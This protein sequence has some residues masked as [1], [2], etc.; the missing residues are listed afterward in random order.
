MKNLRHIQHSI[1]AIRNLEEVSFDTMSEESEKV[2]FALALRIAG[3]PYHIRES[4]HQEHFHYF[5]RAED[6]D[7]C[8]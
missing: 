3:I 8:Q 5:S 1:I 4:G 2:H 7:L 6:C